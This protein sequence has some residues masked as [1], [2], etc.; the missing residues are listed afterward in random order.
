MHDT[1]VGIGVPLSVYSIQKEMEVAVKNVA[2]AFAGKELTSAKPQ[3]AE[4]LND[5]GDLGARYL[6]EPQ[7]PLR[8]INWLAEGTWVKEA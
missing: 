1:P 2:A 4:W 3:R 8:N 6:T 5:I 7:I